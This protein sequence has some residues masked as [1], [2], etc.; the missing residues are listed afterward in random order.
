MGVNAML[1]GDSVHESKKNH[2]QNITYDFKGYKLDQDPTIKALRNQKMRDY[3]ARLKHFAD[4]PMSP[5]SVSERS[6]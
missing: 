4:N 2:L 1:T 5:V 3:M 6:Q